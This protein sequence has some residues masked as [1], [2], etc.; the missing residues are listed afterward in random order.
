MDVY[1]GRAFYSVFCAYNGLDV[2]SLRSS[3]EVRDR[4]AQLADFHP[5]RRT[6]I[7]AHIHTDFWADFC[8]N[9]CTNI[10]TVHRANI[11]F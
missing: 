6:D 11:D 10:D 5:D 9:F 2:P 3:Y 8:T 1:C 7:L 4:S